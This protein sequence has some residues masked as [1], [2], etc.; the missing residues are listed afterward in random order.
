[1]F[2]Q[3][4]S[5]F[6]L[7][8]LFFF[9]FA[10]VIFAIETDVKVAVVHFQP[11]FQQTSINVERLLELADEAGSHG[12]KIVVFPELATSGYSYFNRA[13]V[14][15]VAE[16]IPGK[17]TEL[18]SQV[19]KKHAMYIIVGMP[20]LET[21][22]NLFFNSAVLIDPNGEIAGLY[23]KHSHLMESSWSSL[24]RGQV[25]VFETMYGKLAILICADVSH[26][27][28]SAQA[29]GAKIL[30]LPTN[31]GVNIDLLKVRALEGDC[32]VILANRYGNEKDEY[33]ATEI[34]EDFNEETFTLL[35][36]FSY[37]FQDGKSLIVDAT[38]EVKL[39]LED[40]CDS[41]GY[42][43]LTLQ[44][45]N[46]ETVVRRPELYA[47]LGNN[48][49]DSYCV[50]CMNLPSARTTLV[51]AAN[52]KS[53]NSKE[54]L[55]EIKNTLHQLS[56]HYFFFGNGLRLV[57]FPA[58]V[59]SDSS[60]EIEKIIN[61]L[62]NLSREY[63]LDIVIGFKQL[64]EGRSS[65]TSYLLTS[66]QKCFSY[67]R[68]HKLLSET[69]E[70]GEHF[71]VVDRDYGRIAIV[72]DK[73]LWIPETSKVLGKMGV[74]FVAV[75][76]DE[77]DDFMRVLCKVRSLDYLH[78]V[79]ANKSACSGIYAGGFKV[80]PNFKEN[81][82]AVM[83]ELDTEHVRQKKELQIGFDYR[84]ILKKAQ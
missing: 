64:E 65:S 9:S 60:S 75:S 8:Y 78:I 38:G 18:F 71:T 19:A 34:A 40:P 72:Q 74:D 61:H 82:Q 14:R 53:E 66:D 83:M 45:S 33:L 44:I 77:E 22:S 6:R 80:F 49:L 46:K 73:D 59:L 7:F 70:V 43:N 32:H 4:P 25:P 11:Y 67:K 31:G 68:L 84:S 63:G 48:T 54:L 20:E 55:V 5:I 36:P 56:K 12:A 15:Q 24:G 52:L 79:M 2:I 17:T 51:A 30:V 21:E 27:E 23:R 26:A 41:I 35:P 42:C 57:V 76:A 28:L 29:L 47:F 37:N 50:K 81:E 13:Q 62:K 10:S 58:N 69:V 1:M 16:T 39:I 3:T